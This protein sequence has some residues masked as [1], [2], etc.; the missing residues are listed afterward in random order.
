[1]CASHLAKPSVRFGRLC[2]ATPNKF[3]HWF[4]CIYAPRQVCIKCGTNTRKKYFSF[5]YHHESCGT[6]KRRHSIDSTVSI[7]NRSKLCEHAGNISLILV[8]SD[9]ILASPWNLECLAVCMCVCVCN[10]GLTAGAKE[11]KPPEANNETSFCL[12]QNVWLNLLP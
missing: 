2:N 6:C 4:K 7:T 11:N 12:H 10:Y 1:M 5:F 9:S 8:G 3:A